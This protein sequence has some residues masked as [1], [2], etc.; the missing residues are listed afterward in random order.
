[1]LSYDINVLPFSLPGSYLTIGQNRG[2]SHRLVYRT[3]SMKAVSYRNSP[4]WARDFF[5]IALLR[6]GVEIP[7]TFSAQPHRLDLQA[8][9]GSATFVFADTDTLCFRTQGVSLRLVPCKPLSVFYS[10]APNTACLVDGIA[11]GH[12]QL[13]AE[14]GTELRVTQPSEAAISASH[15]TGLP[16][17]ADFV[18][19]GGAFRFS[20]YEGRFRDALPTFDA[21]LGAREQAWQAWLAQLPAVPERY[22]AAAEQ[23]W[24][25]LWSAEVAPSGPITRPAI[26]QSKYWMN[27]IWSWD[28]CF[29]ALAVARANPQLAWDQLLLFF[30]HLDPHGIAPDQ[31]NDLYQHYSFTKPPI[32]GWTIVKLVAQLGLTQ[33]LPYLSQLYEP[34]CRLTDWWYTMRDFDGDGVCQYHHGNDSGWDNA[35]AFD[36]G[37]PTEAADLSAHLVL[38][39]EGLAF[40]ADALGKPLDAQRWRARAEKQLA[41]LVRHGGNGSRFISPLDGR[42]DAPECQSLLNTIP[43][44]LGHR[45][46]PDVR[47]ALIADLQPGGAFLTDYG[48]ATE[49]PA[50]QKYE[51][52]GYWRGPIWAP[53]TYQIFDGLV[54]AGET[55]LARTVAERFCDMCVRAPGFWENYDALTGEGLCCPGYSW[56]AAVFLLLAEWLGRQS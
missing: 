49:S 1:M 8:E 43:M 52:N 24:Y 25:M 47:R 22:R 4:H 26:L 45:L 12:H 41:D 50:S 48:L 44:E 29:S 56:T 11:R 5:E 6:D 17:Q 46:P 35:T 10:P 37:Y 36:Q 15:R 2:Q 39:C 32:Q 16:Y 42:H 30:E 40:M 13:R 27:S 31:I 19:A 34:M 9:G 51:A 55:A 28:N 33:S 18:G 21:L 7:Y 23:A 38:Q 3:C 53:S 20:P 14:D 54:D